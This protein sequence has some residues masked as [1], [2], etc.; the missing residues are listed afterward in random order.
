MKD[1]LPAS[2]LL[3][4]S[5]ISFSSQAVAQSVG[6][7][8][9]IAGETSGPALGEA[10]SS[11][12][13]A[14][15]LSVVEKE[16]II[17][18]LQRG[19]TGPQDERAITGLM[20]DTHGPDLTE[21][22]NRIDRGGDAYDL[23]QLI[24]RDI[25]NAELREE[26]LDHFEREAEPT[27]VIRVVSDIDD[28]VYAN[29]HDARLSK[30]AVYPSFLTFIAELGS[31]SGH[32]VF[33]SARFQRIAGVVDF[34]QISLDM[35][36]R[37]GVLDPVLLSSGTLTNHLLKRHK[38]MAKRKHVYF[39]EYRA[40]FPEYELVFVGD[41]GQGDVRFSLDL[42]REA[43]NALRLVLIH[44]VIEVGAEQRGEWRDR[45]VEA[46]AT[47]VGGGADRP[48]EGA[49]RSNRPGSD[50]QGGGGGLSARRIRLGQPGAVLR[51]APRPGRRRGQRP[52]ACDRSG[53]LRPAV[54]RRSERPA[55][56][57][58]RFGSQSEVAPS[59]RLYLFPRTRQGP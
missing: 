19:S 46:F 35:L 50:R 53:R 6:A 9:V 34:E 3:F 5:F 18:L 47:Y 11:R 52:R 56:Q 15:P 27:G 16:A 41:D 36:R 22:K 28:T 20:L 42:L 43:P 30:N 25:D 38:A 21:L 7:R 45:G 13:R 32:P 1:V 4:L 39:D 8:G 12:E 58:L 57:A 29:H 40:L 51:R 59:A 55:R 24:Y 14:R 48:P 37:K 26:L 2:L 44:D 17:D 31:E 33:L 54:P 49:P 23:H 10:R